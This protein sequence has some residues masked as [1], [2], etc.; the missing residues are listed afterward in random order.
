LAGQA[1]V[2]FDPQRMLVDEVVLCEDG[3]EQERSLLDQVLPLL[4]KNDLLIADR[5]FCTLAFL[6]G[7]KAC[8][9]RFIIREHRAMPSKSLGKPPLCRPLRDRA[10]VRRTIELHDPQTDG[11]SQVR[12]ITIRLKTVTRDGD[13]EIH[14]LTNLP[15]KVSA[16]RVADLY[17]QSWT[18]EQAFNE[19]TT[20]LR[21]ELNTLVYPKVA[22]FAF[23]VAAKQLQR[24]GRSQRGAAWRAW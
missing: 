21:C 12:R 15:S 2:L 22:L 5:N 19:L 4:A 10:S 20:H 11:T 13:Q 9:A 14:V 24:T 17:R 8:G 7:I 1:L 18:L 16:V 3:H 23:W 6:F